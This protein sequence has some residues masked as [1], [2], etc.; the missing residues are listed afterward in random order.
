MKK[1]T[2][3]LLGLALSYISF[4]QK[5]LS[6]PTGNWVL[7][8]DFSDEFSDGL[9]PA[10]WDNDPADWGPW[11]WKP[12]RTDVSNGKLKLT[13]D[14]DKHERDG[15][16]LYFTSGMIRSKKDIQYGYFE[17]K[18][19]G[20][21][22]HPGV[23]PA[24]WTYS[25][26]QPLIN[27]VKYN[28]I[29]FPEIQQRLRNVNTIDWNVIRA[30]ENGKRTSVRYT[31]GA[32]VGPSFD[33]REAYHVYA[34]NWTPDIIEFYID[35]VKVASH[36]NVYQ[37]HRQYLVVSMGL[38]EPYYEY[39]N[40]QRVAVATESRPA[41]FPTTMSVEY[42]RVWKPGT[43]EPV[44]IETPQWDENQTYTLSDV[45]MYQYK[46][47]SWKSRTDGNCIPTECGRWKDLTTIWDANAT[48]TLGDVVIYNSK[49]W[50]YQSRTDGNA[51]PGENS[52]WK[53]LSE[54]LKSGKISIT[55]GED[56]CKT[57][58]VQNYPNPFEQSTT[59]SYE[60][61]EAGK[62]I[63]DV[64]DINGSKILSLV[65]ALQDTGIYNVKVDASQL[66]GKGVYIYKL[67][68]DNKT[69]IKRMILK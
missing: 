14:W 11:S 35:G 20:A 37:F 53:D 17:V 67:T 25:I 12:E 18:M 29:D 36:D 9:D 45:V 42:V 30:D 62:V 41:G 58:L 23:C 55:Q 61:A 57:D 51:I 56:I 3:I 64:F 32:G 6:D 21:A 19:K 54:L 38:R 34:C 7:Q 1:S 26:G 52:K 28:E 24:F 44:G 13:M 2:L 60:I 33:P 15:N 22:L 59:I 48:Y 16:Q 68:M 65:N 5:P 10:K 46:K 49:E 4:S 31:T 8:T 69:Q 27:G 40:G 39:V 47:W 50:R 63:L 66:R 43:E